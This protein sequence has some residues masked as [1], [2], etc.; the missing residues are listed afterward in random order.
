MACIALT[1]RDCRR[2]TVDFPLRKTLY[3][4]RVAGRTAGQSRIR[5]AL[6]RLGVDMASQTIFSKLV[7]ERIGFVQGVECVEARI[8]NTRYDMVVSH[9]IDTQVRDEVRCPKGIAD[10]GNCSSI[11]CL[12]AGLYVLNVIARCGIASAVELLPPQ[13]LQPSGQTGC[14]PHAWCCVPAPRPGPAVG[15]HDK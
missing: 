10:I 8:R 15:R 6:W 2:Q 7:D 1:I 14:C 4:R 3:I 12:N 13:D 9:G 11:C 5:R